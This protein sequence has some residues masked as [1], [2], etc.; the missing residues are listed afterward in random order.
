DAPGGHEQYVP[1]GADRL[2]TAE[3]EAAAEPVDTRA[4]VL[5]EP[6]VDGAGKRVRGEQRSTRLLEVRRREHR[7]ARLHAHHGEVLER[8]VRGAVRPVVETAADSDD[9]Y[10]QPVVH[11]SVADELV[12]PQRREGR[13]R[14]DVR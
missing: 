11:G 3:P 4:V 7:Q 13:D 2:R 12:R 5:A 1:A 10:R 14:V 8:V 9:P 6:E